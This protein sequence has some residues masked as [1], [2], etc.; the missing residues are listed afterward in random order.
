[1]DNCSILGLAPDQYEYARRAPV[2]VED[3][4]GRLC[5]LAERGLVRPP[6]RERLPLPE[7]AEGLQR[8]LD[9]TMVGRVTVVP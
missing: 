3:C 8:L 1:V 6:I 5:R 9:G 7:A 2:V 4:Y